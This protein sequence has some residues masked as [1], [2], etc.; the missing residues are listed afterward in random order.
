MKNKINSI[1]SVFLIWVCCS[2]IDI[3]G[4]IPENQGENKLASPQSVDTSISKY[5][6]EKILNPSV[7][8]Y[9][10]GIKRVLTNKINLFY[11]VSGT[12]AS[13]IVWPYDKDISEAIEDDNFNELEL[14]APD[15]LGG[16][17]VIT[18]ASVFTHL[19]GRA[20]R[21]PHLANT[22]LY[23]L[24]AYFTTVLITGTTKIIVQRTRPNGENNLS[25]PSGHTS[26]MFT[27]ASVLDKRYG[28]KVGIPS[29][30][31]AGFVGISRIKMQKHFP[32][33]VIA[34]A[35]LG[36]IVGRS[37]VPSKNNNKSAAVLPVFYR[38]YVGISYQVHF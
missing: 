18:G 19:F 3:F 27:V 16:F 12:G 9:F 13:L 37:F 23:L 36:I 17:F 32:T 1:T 20:I 35:A 2:P 15:K 5:P 25:F 14:Q 4:Q 22:G 6:E 8:Q 24:E 33:D 26:G 7:N 30:L 31:L 28:Y 38:N 34:G 10:S 11:L 21:K 29:Y